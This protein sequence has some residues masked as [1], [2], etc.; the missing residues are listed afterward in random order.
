VPDLTKPGME[1]ASGGHLAV[2]PRLAG[3]WR[4]TGGGAESL[5]AQLLMPPRLCR[6]YGAPGELWLTLY[7]ADAAAAL[8]LDLQWF[9]KK[10]TRLPEALWCSFNP[11]LREPAQWRL[12]KLG[13][14]IDPADTVPA[15]GRHLHAV[16]S[17]VRC[18]GSDGALSIETLDAPL[19]APGCRALLRCHDRA[20]P[21]HQGM[22]FNLY[23]NVYGTNFTMW[24]DQDARFRF[25]VNVAGTTPA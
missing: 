18:G 7:A 17:G 10:A 15:G 2:C 24:Y 4:K 23:N 19:V 21:L 25:R 6:E 14:W 11:K 1:K 13:Q 3:L 9:D 16:W 12:D 20:L 22:H 5:V 8:D